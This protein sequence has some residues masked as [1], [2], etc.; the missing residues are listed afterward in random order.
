MNTLR[1]GNNMDTA[2]QQDL[3]EFNIM[4]DKA[5]DGVADMKG[6]GPKY[7]G[8]SHRGRDV[9]MFFPKESITE[10]DKKYG[11]DMAQIV[12]K[13]TNTF[14][15]LQPSFGATLNMR[16]PKTIRNYLRKL[17]ESI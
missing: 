9:Q 6:K 7:F 3:A 14:D 17:L 16:E 1:S 5:L 13:E 4:R 12:P 2:L 11:M 15:L 8:V 10:L